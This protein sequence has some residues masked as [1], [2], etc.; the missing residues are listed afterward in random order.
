MALQIILKNSSVSGNEPTAGQLANGELA[1]NYHADGPFITCK[2]TAGVVR[3][4]TGVWV[5]ATAPS[6]PTPGEMWLDISINPAQ[7]KIYKDAGDA[8]LTV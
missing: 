3:K 6:S 1:L 4:V 7:F 5:N 2:D 8:W